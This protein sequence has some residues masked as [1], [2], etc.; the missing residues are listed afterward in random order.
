MD[1][2]Y[3]FFLRVYKDENVQTSGVVKDIQFIYKYKKAVTFFLFFYI[4]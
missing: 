1:F 4:F 2:S 3:C